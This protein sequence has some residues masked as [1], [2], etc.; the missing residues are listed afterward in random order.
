M[1]QRIDYIAHERRTSTLFAGRLA[2]G[3]SVFALPEPLTMDYLWATA[4]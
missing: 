1:H 4:L 2:S 3:E